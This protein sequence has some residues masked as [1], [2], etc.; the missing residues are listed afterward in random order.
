MGTWAATVEALLAERGAA[1][2]GYAVALTG[3]HHAAED[4]LQDA[5]VKTFRSGRGSVTVNEAHAYVKRAMQSAAIDS[6]RRRRA[7]PEESELTPH[8]DAAAPDPTAAV[9]NRNALL[10]ALAGLTPRERTC[11]VMRFFDGYSAVD[12]SQRLGLSPG[13]VRKYLSDA[14]ATLR[15]RGVDYG[16]HPSDIDDAAASVPL[17]TRPSSR[18]TTNGARA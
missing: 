17:L 14:T 1:L 5:L 15:Q 3:N 2:H 7:R 11:M 9:V 8:T 6:H 18:M 13:T 4:L 16:L 12:I 10:H